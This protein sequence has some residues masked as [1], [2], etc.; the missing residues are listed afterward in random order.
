VELLM[1]Q[2]LP[3][4]PGTWQA[5][6]FL[7]Y[8]SEDKDVALAMQ[9][10]IDNYP[11]SKKGGTISVRP[12]PVADELSASIL[13]NLQ[14]KIRDNHFGVFIYTPVDRE[15]RRESKRK[16]RDN[17]V[18]ETGLFMG[19]KDTR[20]TIILLPKEY[21]VTPSDLAGIVCIEYPYDG[22]KGAEGQAEGASILGPVGAEVADWI[23]KVMDQSSAYQDEPAT[24]QPP[25]ETSTGQPSSALEM[26][27][28]GLASQAAQ[29]KL[30]RMDGDVWE[31]RLVVHAI[32]GVGRVMA[33]DPPEAN[34]RYI[35]V[36]FGLLTGRFGMSELFV[37]SI[38]S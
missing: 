25:P 31:G 16:A 1:T 29:N 10:A 37:A 7:A 14:N 22:V 35:T 38:G 2:Q 19:K 11:L 27:S 23:K 20:H 33:W 34:P 15:E 6:V 12:W 8:A 13:Q 28:A 4:T 21:E 5:K 32:Y 36:Q 30:N 26:I 24:G 9:A 3:E 18:F 17:V